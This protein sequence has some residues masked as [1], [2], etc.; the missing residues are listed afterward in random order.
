[1]VGQE[2][3]GRRLVSKIETRQRGLSPATALKLAKALGVPVSRF[4][5]SDAEWQKWKRKG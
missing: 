1:M 2:V 5:K 4:F 3:A